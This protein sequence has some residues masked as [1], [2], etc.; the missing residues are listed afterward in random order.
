MTSTAVPIQDPVPCDSAGAR[1]IGFSQRLR[2]TAR[3]AAGRFPT[4]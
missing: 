4:L 3:T 2:G 1:E